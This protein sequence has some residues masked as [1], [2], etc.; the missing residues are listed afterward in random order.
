MSK[1]TPATKA[2]EKLGV[3]F[4]L[5]SYVYDSSADSIGLQ[6][7]EALGVE[8]C[9]MLKT[10]MAEV[11]GK[12][13]CVVVRSDGEV[14]MKKLAS[15]FGGKA[16]KM[17]R[18]ADAERLTGYHV[19]GISP[20]GQKK[21]VPVAIEAAALGHATVF[22]NGGQRGLQVELDPDDAMQALAAI[23]PALTV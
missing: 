17:M 13:V 12:P 6:A 22:L 5:H 8:P 15:A 23:A 10:L 16:A 7:A 9:R 11:D 18:P 3:K 20:F 14:S 19:G 1:T 21:R 2:L 4:V